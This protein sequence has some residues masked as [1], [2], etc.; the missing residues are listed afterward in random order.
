MSIQRDRA[1]LGVIALLYIPCPARSSHAQRLKASRHAPR[2]DLA[3]SRFIALDRAIS[4]LGNVG[5]QPHFCRFFVGNGG[6]GRSQKAL[7]NMGY[8]HK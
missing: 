1:F 2:I 6:A 5:L 3:R 4:W 8:T 7:Q